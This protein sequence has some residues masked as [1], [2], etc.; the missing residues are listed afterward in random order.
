MGKGYT[1]ALG[2]GNLAGYP[3][4]TRRVGY[5]G[6]RRRR[7]RGA[8]KHNGVKD[9]SGEVWVEET[10]VEAAIPMRGGG[11]GAAELWWLAGCIRSRHTHAWWRGRRGGAV[12]AGRLHQIKAYPC[13]VAG[14]ARRSYCGWPAASDQGVA[15]ASGL[16]LA[17]QDA[18]ARSRSRRSLR[19]LSSRHPR[20]RCCLPEPPTNI[21]QRLAALSPAEVLG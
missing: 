5:A 14:T 18:C 16:L 6:K 13:V 20:M 2:M 11:D 4:P 9:G 10:S 12:V 3:I 1:V 17:S 19:T 8:E 21:G 7:S 15:V